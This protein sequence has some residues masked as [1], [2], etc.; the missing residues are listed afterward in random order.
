MY[1]LGETK[2]LDNVQVPKRWQ[3]LSVKLLRANIFFL[4]YGRWFLP[5]LPRPEAMNLIV[6]QPIEVP[7][8]EKPTAEQVDLLHGRYFSSLLEAF[9]RHKLAA[10]GEKRTI[11]I[12]PPLKPVS[13]KQWETACASFE[14]APR[15]DGRGLAQMFPAKSG[16]SL[17]LAFTCTFWMTVFA[18]IFARCMAHAETFLLDA[19]FAS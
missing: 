4:P 16:D 18:F 3:R 7:R 11:S 13:E 2:V 5:G 9:E 10:S 19:I 15:K 14:T 8:I 1:N 6:G 12:E 17:E